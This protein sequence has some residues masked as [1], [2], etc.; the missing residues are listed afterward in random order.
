MSL[1]LLHGE[2]TWVA[3]HRAVVEAANQFGRFFTGQITAAGRVPPAKVLVIGGGVAGLSAIGTAKNMGAV[4]RVFDTRSV[5]P[6][7][8]IL[9]FMAP[10]CACKQGCC[11]EPWQATRFGSC[12]KLQLLP[13]ASEK[14]SCHDFP[15]I[16]LQPLQ[17]PFPWLMLRF[18]LSSKWLCICSCACAVQLPRCVQLRGQVCSAAVADSQAAC[19]QGS[20]SRAGQEPGC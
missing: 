15:T 9:L 20:S 19:T 11:I 14:L 13:S 6:I 10:S 2:I 1:Y 7:C 17:R 5:L 8:H 18:C 12:I 16:N 3:C 4:V